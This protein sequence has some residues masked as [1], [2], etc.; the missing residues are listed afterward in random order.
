MARPATESTE[1]LALSRFAERL[2]EQVGA[3]KVLLFGSHARGGAR[4][5]SDY[6]LIVVSSQYDGMRRRD[7]GKDLRELFYEVGGNAP[8]DLICLTPEEFAEAKEKVTLISAVLPETIDLL[9][10]DT[11]RVPVR[12]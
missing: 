6:D 5:D 8:M 2:R 7:R 9:A 1:S 10:P 3:E 11:D 12:G 4:P